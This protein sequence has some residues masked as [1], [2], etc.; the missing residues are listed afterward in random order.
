MINNEY[1][2]GKEILPSDQNRV[3]EQAKFTYSLLGKAFE[4]QTKMIEEQEQKQVK[5]LEDLKTEENKEENKEEK[6]KSVEDLFPKEMRTNKIK[7]E[8][9]E[10]KKWKEIIKRKDFKYESNK[11]RFDFQQFETIRSFGDSIYNGKINIKKQ[12]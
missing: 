5:A 1:L 9:D 3:I 12:K 11:Y 4:K 10:I 7:N 2:T 8:I 6:I